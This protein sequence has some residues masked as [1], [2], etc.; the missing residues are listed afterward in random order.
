MERRVTHRPLIMVAA[1]LAVFTDARAALAQTVDE[2][3]LMSQQMHGYFDGELR[4]A[5]VFAGL[6]AG[7]GY[8]GG[9][10]LAHATDASRAA[11]VPVLAVGVIQLAAGLGLLIRTGAQ[12]RD[13]DTQIAGQPAAFG[14]EELARM[15]TVAFWFDVYR[16]VEATLLVGGAGTA[17]LGAVLEEDLAIGAGLGL[18]S[19]AAVMLVL[20]AFAE[21]RA[22]RYIE[23]IRRFNVGPTVSLAEDG[24]HVSGLSLRLSY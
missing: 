14:S 19:Q 18:A 7:S 3:R 12:V 22:D 15:E 5:A 21:D 16:T 8:A 2:R 17:A 13:L 20:D 24:R 9:V 4:E 6:G 10:L 11:A 23:N 1:F